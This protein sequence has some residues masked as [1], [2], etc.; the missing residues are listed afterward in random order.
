MLF[1]LSE[2]GSDRC[3]ELIELG[4]WEGGWDEHGDQTGEDSVS[5]VLRGEGAGDLL[6]Q[7]EEMHVDVCVLV[8]WADL[9]KGY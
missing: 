8:C 5:N 9:L 4:F 1:Y 7:G 3:D 6:V 2:Q